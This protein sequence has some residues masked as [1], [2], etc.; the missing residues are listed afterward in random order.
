MET[1]IVQ[2]IIQ[3][4]IGFL[5][6]IFVFFG[7]EYYLIPLAIF[8][9][10]IIYCK[11]DDKQRVLLLIRRTIVAM[12]LYMFISELVLRNI[13][14]R[15]RPFLAIDNITLLGKEVTN[16][17]FPSG[18]ATF[19]MIYCYML[20]LFDKKFIPLAI[21]FVFM[22]SFSRI[23]TGHH[24]PSDVVAGMILGILYDHLAIF[25]IDKFEKKVK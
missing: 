1:S 10:G 8:I 7:Q 2:L 18:H 5:D 22:I 3:N 11:S 4:R 12:A 9:Y 13:F 14:Y 16:S 23:Y 17:S 19:S 15:P 25:L 6:R 21:F 20:V 24:W